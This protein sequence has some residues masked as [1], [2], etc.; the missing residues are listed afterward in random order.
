[1]CPDIY[2]LKPK[3]GKDLTLMQYENLDVCAECYEVFDSVERLK[4]V[5][6]RFARRMSIPEEITSHVGL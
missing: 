2:D 4:A 5:G 1:M 3:K 6:R